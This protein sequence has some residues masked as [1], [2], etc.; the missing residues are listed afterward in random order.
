MQSSE[1]PIEVREITKKYGEQ[2]AVDKISF[3]VPQGRVFGLLGPNG[4]GKT[5]TIR[6]IMNI[7]IPDS[8]SISI[9]GRPSTEV[10]SRAIGYLPEER[11][12]YKKMKVLDHIVFLGEIRGIGSKLART[13]A[14]EWLARLD[15]ESWA[16]KKIEELSKGMQQKIQF[17]G[18][19]IHDPEILILDEPFSGLDPVNARVLKD[20]ILEFKERGKTLLFSTHV[21]EQ[22]EKLCDEIAL[23]N[24]SRI[25]LQGTIANIKRDFSGNRIRVQGSGDFESLRKIDGVSDLVVSNGSAEVELDPRVEKSRFLREASAVCDLDSVM[26]IEASLDEIFIKTV[27]GDNASID[28]STQSAGAT[29]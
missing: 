20:L 17:I 12:L 28:P 18:C 5:T 9:L 1:I 23:V 4:A 8:G 19:V 7:L 29:Q 10:A 21:M 25:V 13:R 26:P 3:V 22:A 14:N 11:G 6:M 27:A 24:R 2:T 16:P 15:I